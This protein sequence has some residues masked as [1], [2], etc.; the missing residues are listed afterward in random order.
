LDRLTLLVEAVTFSVNVAINA[1]KSFLAI[2]D[3]GGDLLEL[4]IEKILEHLQK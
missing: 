2:G 1:S 3:Y 4:D